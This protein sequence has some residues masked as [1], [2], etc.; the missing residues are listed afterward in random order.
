MFYLYVRAFKLFDATLLVSSEYHLHS[1]D[2]RHSL[3]VIFLDTE[4]NKFPIN[5]GSFKIDCFHPKLLQSYSNLSCGA[6]ARGLTMACFWS[7]SLLF[8]MR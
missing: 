4:Q 1:Y 3:H 6:Y 7:S 5:I 2:F 8:R